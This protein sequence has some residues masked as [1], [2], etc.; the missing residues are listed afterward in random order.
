ML[1][2]AKINNKIVLYILI[3]SV[4]SCG[5]SP[6]DNERKVI[7]AW[8]IE[9]IDHKDAESN[10]YEGALISFTEDG[11]F[12]APRRNKNDSRTGKWEI[13]KIDEVDHLKIDSDNPYINGIYEVS[14]FSKDDLRPFQ[15][16][17][18]PIQTNQSEYKLG[19]LSSQPKDFL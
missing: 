16:E 2:K 9:S 11:V 10:L 1:P 7:G 3:V 17:I 8:T 18:I 4:C 15:L 14:Q 5:V 12:R 19:R 13:I 6:S